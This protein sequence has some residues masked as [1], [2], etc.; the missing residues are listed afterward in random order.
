MFLKR[1]VA[2]DRVEEISKESDQRLKAGLPNTTEGEALMYLGLMAH[3]TSEAKT[4]SE[5]KVTKEMYKE[6]KDFCSSKGIDPNQFIIDVTVP[7]YRCDYRN[8]VFVSYYSAAGYEI[9]TEGQYPTAYWIDEA[10]TKRKTEML[11][12]ETTYVTSYIPDNAKS[13]KIWVPK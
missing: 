1:C 10:R 5:K 9:A 8:K 12:G 3:A 7:F 2:N 4:E 11:P 13:W 6:F